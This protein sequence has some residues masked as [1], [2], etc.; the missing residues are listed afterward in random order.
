M[1]FLLAL[2]KRL[3]TWVNTPGI[4]FS[5]INSM[6]ISVSSSSL[7]SS[8]HTLHS[9][10]FFSFSQYS[11]AVFNKAYHANPGAV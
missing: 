8:G 9:L 2:A 11:A 6:S 3:T 10:C 1:Y 7:N 4:P 5:N